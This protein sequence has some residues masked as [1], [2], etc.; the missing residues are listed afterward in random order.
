MY[1][2]FEWESTTHEFIGEILSTNIWNTLG[3]LAGVLVTLFYVGDLCKR[4][5]WRMRRER[6]KKILKL[7]EL[8]E[9]QQRLL[10]EY[11][12]KMDEKNKR[13]QIK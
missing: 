7:Q 1:V 9:E 13:K 5:I 6:K 3:G 2:L 12:Q 8:A 4:W 10:E 11:E